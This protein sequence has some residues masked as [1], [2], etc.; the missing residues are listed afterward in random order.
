MEYDLAQIE[1]ATAWRNIG[2][3]TGGSKYRQHNG[4]EIAITAKKAIG[5]SENGV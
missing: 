5:I 1:A 2:G 4:I 3:V